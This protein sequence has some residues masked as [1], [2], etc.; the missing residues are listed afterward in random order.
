M[1]TFGSQARNAQM[2]WADHV[3]MLSKFMAKFCN[4]IVLRLPARY[5]NSF[6]HFASVVDGSRKNA[7]LAHC[8]LRL[9]S[10][11]EQTMHIL[12]RT[13]G[14]ID[15]FLNLWCSFEPLRRSQVPLTSARDIWGVGAEAP[16][17]RWASGHT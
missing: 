14:L 2:A 4:Y 7:G 3:V 8:M 17:T 12:M 10:E 16:D 1:L 9:R 5:N 6:V 13:L 15:T 11:I